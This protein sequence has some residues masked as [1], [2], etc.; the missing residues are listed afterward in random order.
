[1]KTILK[2]ES[3]LVKKIKLGFSWPVLLLGFIYP[4]IQGYNMMGVVLSLFAVFFIIIDLPEFA[5]IV[6]LIVAFFYNRLYIEEL[7]Y[8]GF[9]PINKKEHELVYNYVNKVKK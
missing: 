9:K 4:F 2:H 8:K 3:G 6:W 5:N 7:I 1:M